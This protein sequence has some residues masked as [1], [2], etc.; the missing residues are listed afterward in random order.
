MKRENASGSVRTSNVT[1][2][3]DSMSNRS[4]ESYT[5]ILWSIHVQFLSFELMNSRY[6][7]ET[8]PGPPPR[9]PAADRWPE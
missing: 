4:P 6:H 3:S 5:E 2:V 9:P 7:P 8:V 1:R